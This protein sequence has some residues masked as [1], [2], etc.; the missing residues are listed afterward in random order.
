ML[1]SFLGSFTRKQRQK[2]SAACSLLGRENANSTSWIHTVEQCGLCASKFVV[3]SSFS[4]VVERERERERSEREEKVHC[5]S[6]QISLSPLSYCNHI[7]SLLAHFPPRM[8]SIT[9]TMSEAE[10]RGLLWATFFTTK[11]KK[12]S[13]LKSKLL[14]TSIS[15]TQQNCSFSSYSKMC[16]PPLSSTFTQFSALLVQS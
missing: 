5:S 4:S 3:S 15:K 8:V 9:A 10:G 11:K 6:N 16:S 13:F 2:I 14:E 1:F 12:K 7:H